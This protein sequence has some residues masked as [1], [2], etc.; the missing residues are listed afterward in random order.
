MMRSRTFNRLGLVLLATQAQETEI[1]E[2]SALRERGFFSCYYF[3]MVLS[4]DL[5]NLVLYCVQQLGVTLGVG[6]ETILLVAYV[7]AIRDGVV[8]AKEAQFSRAVRAVLNWGLAFIIISGVGITTLHIMAGQSAVVLTPA[9]LFKWALILLALIFTLVARY[10]SQ[11]VLEGVAGATWYALFLVHILAPVTTWSNLLELYAV[12]LSGFTLCWWALVPM[13]SRRKSEAPKKIDTIAATL[14]P[15]PAAPKPFP[16]MSPVKPVPIPVPPP[17]PPPAPVP[18]PAPKPPPVPSVNPPAI[19]ATQPVQQQTPLVA[20]LDKKPE[21]K[22][23]D[24][25]KDPG[26]PAI[27][28]MPKTPQ[29]LDT[30]NRASVVKFD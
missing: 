19:V 17:P 18:P 30:Q 5:I 3:Y 16:N 13:F 25:D 28:V 11:S 12:W 7:S 9:Y 6:A 23:T 26:L 27:R 1:R 10:A 24:P 14:P 8:D 22:I 21:V 4:A 29:D 2:L 15:K 20:P